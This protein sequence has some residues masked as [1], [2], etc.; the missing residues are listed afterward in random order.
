[1]RA[2]SS[3]NKSDPNGV[4]GFNKTLIAGYALK[5]AANQDK[6]PVIIETVSKTQKITLHG[7]VLLT[8]VVA[9]RGEGLAQ[10]RLVYFVAKPTGTNYLSGTSALLA[11]IDADGFD[12][13]S[14]GI[15]K[16]TA[17]DAASAPNP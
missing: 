11:H 14:D 17:T 7:E 4:D 13:V 2:L 16:T 6:L 3:C 8:S 9:E 15:D 1:V 5:R 10:Q 12:A